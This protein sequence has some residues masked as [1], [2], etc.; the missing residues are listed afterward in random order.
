MSSSPWLFPGLL[1]FTS[2]VLNNFPSYIFLKGKYVA[3]LVVIKCVL[4]Y[5]EHLGAVRFAKYPRV[6]LVDAA[7][8]AVS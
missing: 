4:S 7:I 8:E 5:Q 6:E 1:T 2:E 3:K